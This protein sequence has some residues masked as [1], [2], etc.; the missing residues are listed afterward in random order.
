[1]PCHWIGHDSVSR[2]GGRAGT[3]IA[4][5]ALL[6]ACSAAQSNLQVQGSAGSMPPGPPSLPPSTI[7][8]TPP[9]LPSPVPASGR[10]TL[11]QAVQLGLRTNPQI[12]AATSAIASAHENYNSQKSPINPTLGY[13]ALNDAVAP[14]NYGFGFDIGSNWT[15]YATV[16]TSGASRYRTW[17]SREQY[18]QAQFDA[19]ATGLS[20]ALSIIS[21]YANLQIA[22]SALDV[23]LKVYDNMV[24]LSGLTEKRFETGTGQQADAVRAR[25]AAIQEQQ[26]VIADVANVEAARATLNTQL[27]R[28]QDAPIDAAEPLIYKPG[29]SASLDEITK[30]AENQRPELQ[31]A[32]ANLSSLRAA[33]GLERS[34][35]YPDILFGK[36]LSATG[37]VWFGFSMPVDLGSIRGAVAKAKADV[38][39][40]EAQV[41]VERQSIDLDVKTSY[42]NLEAARKQ[43][44]TY[45]GGVLSMSQALVDQVRHGYELGANTI[46]DI[47]TAENTYRSVETAYYSAIG[48]YE[49]AGYTLRHSISDLPD[50]FSSINLNPI[51]ATGTGALSGARNTP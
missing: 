32:K 14:L 44:E 51:S 30:V 18:H 2:L 10:L 6:A 36:D 25:I 40:Q 16:E 23:E 29:P 13:G 21:A 9:A 27:G 49:V 46:V 31:S 15:Y 3:V 26:N 5:A 35:Y 17:Q 50:A 7:L 19:K 1:M 48:A 37:V 41:E 4:V 24:K 11:S 42:I 39:T 38:K 28:P 47:I 12:A 20:L 43:V 22:N 8:D 45:E 33:V 34:N